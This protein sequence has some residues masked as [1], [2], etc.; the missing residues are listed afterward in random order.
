MFLI[1]FIADDRFGVCLPSSP[2]HEI[3]GFF[4][5]SLGFDTLVTLLVIYRVF[6]LKREAGGQFSRSPLVQLFV[7]EGLWYFFVVSIANL[8]NGLMFAQKEKSLQLNAVPF[9]NMLPAILA[10]RLILDLREHGSAEGNAWLTTGKGNV[11]F[12]LPAFL[13]RSKPG[14]TR[15]HLSTLRFQNPDRL[16]PTN[17]GASATDS[18]GVSTVSDI[19][20]VTTDGVGQKT[21][22]V[23]GLTSMRE[24]GGDDGDD[25]VDARDVL[26]SPAKPDGDE[27][28]PGMDN[29]SY[30]AYQMRPLRSQGQVEPKAGGDEHRQGEAV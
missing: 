25:I 16:R 26:V 11:G 29:Q 24:V 3:F 5:A 4:L 1:P 10:C 12:V 27:A 23:R 17:P 8:I 15:P 6:Q 14:P 9:S 20:F 19:Q 18:S 7:S 13:Y 22:F 28:T 30:L 21:S 2:G